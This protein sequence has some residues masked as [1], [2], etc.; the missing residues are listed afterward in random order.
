MLRTSLGIADLARAQGDG[1]NA[2]SK[3]PK[4]RA[5]KGFKTARRENFRFISLH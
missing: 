1:N 4:G 3:A 2:V 5:A